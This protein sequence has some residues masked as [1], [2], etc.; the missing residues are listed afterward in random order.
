MIFKVKNAITTQ[1]NPID[2]KVL[3]LSASKA[4]S[5]ETVH[6]VPIRH[7]GGVQERKHKHEGNN[8]NDPSAGSP[9]ET[10]YDFYFL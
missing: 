9:T 5:N 6:K 7:P 1:L 3:S 10:L 4:L 8:G 2:K